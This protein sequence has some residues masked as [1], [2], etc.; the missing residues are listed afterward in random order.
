MTRVA[1][2]REDRKA[3]NFIDLVDLGV[4]L[5][6]HTDM[7][8]L[9]FKR[10]RTVDVQS[11]LFEHIR[12]SHQETHPEAFKWDAAYWQQLRSDYETVVNGTELHI[13]NRDPIAK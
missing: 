1:N 13:S 5:R 8:S 4:Y 6:N 3:K 2:A 10:T 12:Q 11:A 9:S 7:I